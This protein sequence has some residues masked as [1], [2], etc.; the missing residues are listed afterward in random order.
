MERVFDCSQTP[1]SAR[2]SLLVK[3]ET[4]SYQD[5]LLTRGSL[6]CFIVETMGFVVKILTL[7]LG[8]VWP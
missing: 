2:S 3:F 5:T 4:T 7:I 1:N 8:S 6:I